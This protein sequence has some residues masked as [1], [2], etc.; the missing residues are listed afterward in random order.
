ME[1]PAANHSK[2]RSNRQPVSRLHQ[3]RLLWNTRPLLQRKKKD[4]FSKKKAV[5]DSNE[6]VDESGPSKKQRL[7]EEA[8]EEVRSDDLNIIMNL[9]CLQSLI[10]SSGA[11]C[12]ECKEPSLRVTEGGQ[13][14]V[15]GPA[16]CDAGTGACGRKHSG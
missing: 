12:P 13:Q 4:F 6:E 15:L 11:L 2:L 8:V 1:K 14:R 9:S 3:R 7:E 5:S 16:G 10:D